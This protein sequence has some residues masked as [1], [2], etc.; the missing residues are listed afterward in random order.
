V[1][2]GSRGERGA[3]L[4]EFAFI[5]PI[6]CLI[7]FAIIDF[8]VAYN[9]YLSVRQGGREG[10]RQA[11]VS[12]VGTNSACSTEGFSGPEGSD[13]DKLFCLIK[14]RVGLAHAGT[15]VKLDFE[16]S[17]FTAK[18]S[19][20]VCV[21]YPVTSTTG[22]LDSLIGTRTVH[23]EVQMRVELTTASLVEAQETALPGG[24]WS[25]CAAE[26]TA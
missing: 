21:Q 9:D 23:T 10:A 17:T 20:A 14:D 2:A 1:Q 8:G 3:S 6:L 16:G 19:L 15:R 25:W 11:V 13:T 22:F 26:P 12:S 5:V 7:V 24:D 4:V 18:K